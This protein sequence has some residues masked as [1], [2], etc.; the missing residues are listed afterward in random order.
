[1]GHVSRSIALINRLKKQ[2]NKLYFAGNDEQIQ[3]INSYFIDIQTYNINDYP[4]K[5]GSKGKFTL[6]LLKTFRPL[7]RGFKNEFIECKALTKALNIDVII[8]DHRYGFKS[9]SAMNIF[10]T[11]QIN[12]PLK[13]WQFPFQVLHKKLMNTFDFIWIP[14]TVDSKYAGKLSVISNN[15]KFIPIG[16]I[17]R[18]ELYPIETAKTINSTIIVS[19][20]KTLALEFLRNQIL[21]HKKEDKEIPV[22][23]CWYD[24]ESHELDLSDFKKITSW[25]EA[26]NIILKSKK[27]ITRSGYSTLMDITYLNCECEL[28]PTKGQREQEYLF[29][30]WNTRRT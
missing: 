21:L 22:V 11:H 1:M 4:F 9:E 10:I 12:L 8:S 18:F 6:D 30:L 7:Y 15:S 19:G 17:S 3:I 26:D 28:T 16:V 29:K 23:V 24:F 2:N 14:D 20:P 13:W 27:L 25:V 5:F